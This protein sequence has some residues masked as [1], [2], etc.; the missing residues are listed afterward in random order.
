MSEEIY[1]IVPDPAHTR[2]LRRHIFW[3]SL[4]CYIRC[5]LRFWRWHKFP[6]WSY[7]RRIRKMHDWVFDEL[8]PWDGTE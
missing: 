2:R 6:P 5:W 8:E 3:F 1:T 7:Y 4:W